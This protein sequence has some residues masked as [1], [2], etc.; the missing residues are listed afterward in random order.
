[1]VPSKPTILCLS[2]FIDA[3]YALRQD[4]VLVVL[5]EAAKVCVLDGSQLLCSFPVLRDYGLIAEFENPDGFAPLRYF[6]LSEA[7]IDF[8][9]RALA[10]WAARAWHERLA[11]RLLN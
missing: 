4:C 3:L 10:A 2:E 1:M 5:D 8:A 6:R 11:L 9:D 7:G